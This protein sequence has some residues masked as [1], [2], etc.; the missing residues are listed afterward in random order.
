MACGNEPRLTVI[1]T[2]VDNRRRQSG[3][4][5]A[6]ARKIECT[7][8]KREIAFRRIKRDLH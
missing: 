1:E 6:G 3:E 2:V 7:V 5:L 8:L 4:Q